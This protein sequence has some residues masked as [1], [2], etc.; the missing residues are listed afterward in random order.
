LR[1]SL[2][3]ARG[4]QSVFGLEFD[5]L[6]RYIADMLRTRPK[7]PG[8]PPN[9]NSGWPWSKMGIADLEDLSAENLRSNTSR[10]YLC[11]DLDEVVAKVATA[12]RNRSW[13]SDQCNAFLPTGFVKAYR[14]FPP[15]P[16]P[17]FLHRAR[18]R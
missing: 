13:Y 1:T 10:K 14:P 5:V 4:E 16:H 7:P 11:G 18:G 6:W 9:I 3:A 8:G 2:L 15:S 17:I 12:L